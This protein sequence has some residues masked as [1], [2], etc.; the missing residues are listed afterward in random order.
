MR[1]F[2]VCG[3]EYLV[4]KRIVLVPLALLEDLYS[5]DGGSIS[6]AGTYAARVTD[7][8]DREPLSSLRLLS[9]YV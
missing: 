1:G 9:L 6:P 4:R 8:G 5:T 7:S 3:V 2:T